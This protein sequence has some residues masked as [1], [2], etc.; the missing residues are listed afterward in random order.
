MNLDRLWIRAFDHGSQRHLA[1]P[2]V[3]PLFSR[4]AHYSPGAHA[5][6]K[7]V[8]HKPPFARRGQSPPGNEKPPTRSANIEGGHMDSMTQGSK[9]WW[10]Q[11]IPFKQDRRA[12]TG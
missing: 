4:A 11:D 8:Y 3:D 5:C 7:R 2:P 1:C 10:Q 9:S 12:V 6:G